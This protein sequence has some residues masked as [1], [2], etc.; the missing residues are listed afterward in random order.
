MNDDELLVPTT[1]ELNNL[2][3]LQE[4]DLTEVLNSLEIITGVLYEISWIIKFAIVMYIIF[5]AW[6]LV[7]K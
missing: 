3:T 2:D 1:D 4:T 7:R 5:T 6:K